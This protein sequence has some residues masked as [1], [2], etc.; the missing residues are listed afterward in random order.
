MGDTG[1]RR[2]GGGIFGELQN[3]LPE[4]HGDSVGRRNARR[5]DITTLGI[6][7]VQG[8]L[9]PDLITTL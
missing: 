8:G 4:F 6:L 3:Q 9:P 2:R 1:R 5:D 7:N